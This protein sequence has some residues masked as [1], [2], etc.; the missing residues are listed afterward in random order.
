MF[1]NMV[2]KGT[3]TDIF[4]SIKK[5]STKIAIKKYLSTHNEI[6]LVDFKNFIFRMGYASQSFPHSKIKKIFNEFGFVYNIHIDKY[7]K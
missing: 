2:K 7:I 3:K 5:E 6:K 4:A 1:Q